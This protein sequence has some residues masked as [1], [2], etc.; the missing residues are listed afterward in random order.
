[1][2]VSYFTDG[3]FVLHKIPTRAGATYLS[4]WYDKNG[5]LLDCEAINILGRS[6]RP[7]KLDREHLVTLG[8]ICKHK[9]TV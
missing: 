5:N 8:N 3:G 1:M 4:A 9:E 2:Q 6:Y 7:S